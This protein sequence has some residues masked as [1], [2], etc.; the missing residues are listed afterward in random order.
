M[1]QSREDIGYLLL[2]TIQHVRQQDPTSSIVILVQSRRH[3]EEL[4][5]LL[6]QANVPFRATEIKR[7]AEKQTI[8]TY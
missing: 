4:L 8:Q 7:L 5:P 6:Q 1:D 3:V 2:E